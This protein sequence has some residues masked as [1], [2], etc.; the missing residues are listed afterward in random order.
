[1]SC[2]STQRCAAAK[3]PHRVEVMIRRRA[4]F[5]REVLLR[6]RKT[7]GQSPSCASAG[8]SVEPP[9][10]KAVEGAPHAQTCPSTG[11]KGGAATQMQHSCEQRRRCGRF[12]SV[13]QHIGEGERERALRSLIAVPSEE[14]ASDVSAGGPAQRPVSSRELGRSAHPTKPAGAAMVTGR[15]GQEG[16]S[17]LTASGDGRPRSGFIPVAPLC[18]RRQMTVGQNLELFSTARIERPTC[19]AA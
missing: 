10:T 2:C 12:H 15:Y 19:A 8:W 7:G 18:S 5:S 3:L 1:M 11:A 14:R 6:Q 13:L 9:A 17:M 4:R 16:A